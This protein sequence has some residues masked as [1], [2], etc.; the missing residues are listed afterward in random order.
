MPEL[1][2]IVNTASGGRQGALVLADLQRRFG[3]ELAQPFSLGVLPGV[4]ES[5]RRDGAVL[6]ACGGDGTVAA[7]LEAGVRCGLAIPVGIMPLGTGN[8]LA[9]VLGWPLRPVWDR[10]GVVIAGFSAAHS[11]RID[12]WTV[13]G[14]LARGWY[15]YVSL[16]YDARIAHRFQ[17]LR[18]QHPRLFVSALVNRSIYALASLA[19]ST[20]PLGR[21]LRMALGAGSEL[22]LPRWASALLFT[23][24]PSYA[25]GHCLGSQIVAD[26]GHLDVFALPAGLPLSLALGRLRTLRTLGAPASAAFTVTRPLAVQI[27]GE[28]LLAPPGAYHIAHGGTVPI[29]VP[30][31]PQRLTNR[32]PA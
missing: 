27:D 23:S 26:D 5:C 17:A 24:I 31:A 12:R 30:L 18:R 28:P 16:G 13:D 2:F 10:D 20:Q 14:A 8:D 7:A 19:E 15:N 6:V 32:R 4:L 22:Q 25:G 21:A 3:P 9:R 1:R 11:R 29:L